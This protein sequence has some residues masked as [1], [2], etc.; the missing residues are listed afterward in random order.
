MYDLHNHLLPGIDDGSPDINTSIKLAKIAEEDGI[1][2][3]ICTPHIHPGRYE[4]NL[5][6]I[7]KSLDLFRHAMSVNNINLQVAAAAE[8]RIG[9]E[10]LQGIQNKTLPFL[11]KWENRDVLLLEFPSNSIPVGSDKL[12]KWLLEKNVVPMIAHP[13]RNQVFQKHPEQ[14]NKFITLGCL[15]QVTAGA[16]IGNFGY[17]AK[18]TAENL[19]IQNL[20]TVIATDAHNINY[21][22]PNLSECFNQV[23]QL[24]NKKTAEDIFINTPKTICKYK[25]TG[26]PL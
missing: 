12:I 22:P 18:Q 26:N 21:R 10:I 7:Q 19:L 1:S 16:L 20:I 3:L 14:L 4:N 6:T 5:Q 2:H 9:P 24:T 8:V 23:T 25:F 15:I 13:E 11:G 17:I